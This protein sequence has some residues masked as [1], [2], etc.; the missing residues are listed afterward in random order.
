MNAWTNADT[1]PAV[2]DTEGKGGR[3]GESIKSDSSHWTSW[4]GGKESETHRPRSQIENAFKS[5][6]GGSEHVQS[7]HKAVPKKLLKVRKSWQHCSQE[8]Y[9]RTWIDSDARQTAAFP[10]R[11]R[12]VAR[13]AWGVSPVAPLSGGGKSPSVT[14]SLSLSPA[15]EA[16]CSRWCMC[17]EPPRPQTSIGCDECVCMCVSVYEYVSVC[18]FVYVCVCVCVRVCVCCH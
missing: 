1:C 4:S 3:S 11:W 10:P 2:S 5:H 17:K 18:S 16:A 9:W 8:L 12:T 15:P 13:E 6:S 14:L 7:L